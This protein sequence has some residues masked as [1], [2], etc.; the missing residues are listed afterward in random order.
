MSLS[1]VGAVAAEKIRRHPRLVLAERAEPAGGVDAAL[2]DPGAH[3]LM[4][5][6]TAPASRIAL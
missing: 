1:A 2:A 6:A 4:D 5:H 3:R